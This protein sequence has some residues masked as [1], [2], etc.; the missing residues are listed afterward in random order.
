MAGIVLLIRRAKVPVLPVGVAGTFEAWPCHEDRP[1][2]SPL[3]MTPNKATVC[4]CVGNVIAPEHLLS[5]K[6][7]EMLKHL[8]DEVDKVRTEAY[9]RKRK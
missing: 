4:C 2:W 7:A 5:M 6:P 3:L 1:K 8:Y 9:A